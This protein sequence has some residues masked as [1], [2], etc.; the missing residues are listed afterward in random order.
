MMSELPRFILGVDP[1][2]KSGV[3]LLDLLLED[4]DGA[5]V[6]WPEYGYHLEKL[7]E[8]YRPAVVSESFVINA[9]TVKN[10]QAPWSL[11]GIG[12]ARYLAHKY[13]CPFDLQPP[14]SAKR[15]A[16]NDRLQT[17]GWYR[18]GKGHLADAQRHC[19]LYVTRHGWWNDALGNG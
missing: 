5:E 17:L 10:T 18:P 11:E 2:R 1:G 4:C 8:H 19:L 13:D 14:S 3:A 15:F 12:V 9:M 16:T 7:I 6:S